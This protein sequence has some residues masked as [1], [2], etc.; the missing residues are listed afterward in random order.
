MEKKILLKKLINR[1]PGQ[2][3]SSPPFM[4]PQGSL[5]CSQNPVTGPYLEPVQSSKDKVVPVLLNEH[6]AMKAYWRAE[7]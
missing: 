1:S 6:H 4:Q 2:E 3:M 7:V 5:P